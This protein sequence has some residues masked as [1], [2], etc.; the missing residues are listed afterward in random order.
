MKIYD[1]MIAKG[2]VSFRVSQKVKRYKQVLIDKKINVFQC[3]GYIY[4][5]TNYFFPTFLFNF[6]RH[7]ILITSIYDF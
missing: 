3:D 7:W 4:I 6:Q 5:Y 1:F 2:P